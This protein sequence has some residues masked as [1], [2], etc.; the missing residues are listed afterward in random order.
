MDNTTRTEDSTP[1]QLRSYCEP[2]HSTLGFGGGGGGKSPCRRTHA[3]IDGW[4]YTITHCCMQQ[5]AITCTSVM[6]CF[7]SLTVTDSY[8]VCVCVCVCVCVHVH[9][10]CVCTYSKIK[11]PARCGWGS[12]PSINTHITN[13]HDS[14]GIPPPPIP[15]CVPV[16]HMHMHI[17]IHYTGG[18]YYLI[19]Y[20]GAS[21]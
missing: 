4:M 3:E 19:R 15:A 8:H 11:A 17:P 13:H 1:H 18:L 12:P 16:V 20:I 9:V 7:L 21:T 2:R 5:V 10:L 6:V 14:V